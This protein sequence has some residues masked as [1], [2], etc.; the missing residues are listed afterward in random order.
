MGRDLILKIGKHELFMGR[1]HNY[2]TKTMH[3]EKDLDTLDFVNCMDNTIG[4][5]KKDVALVV[6]YSPNKVE[7][8]QAIW[9]EL[10]GK[11]EGAFEDLMNL[12]C[13]SLLQEMK[14]G[15]P[16]VEIEFIIDE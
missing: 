14:R 9:D 8:L 13:G 2:T 15:N 1:L 16:E 7:E 3:N 10:E 4:E 11:I 6:G 5:L 12:A